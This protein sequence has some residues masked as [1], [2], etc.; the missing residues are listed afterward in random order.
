MLSKIGR[1]NYAHF[2]RRNYAVR[3]TYPAWDS[4]VGLQAKGHEQHATYMFDDEMQAPSS[5]SAIYD[6][7]FIHKVNPADHQKPW[8]TTGH[9]RVI[10]T[11]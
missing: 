6:N 1:R 2:S 11:L 7:T 5:E 3:M 9:P 10:L 8:E 4:G